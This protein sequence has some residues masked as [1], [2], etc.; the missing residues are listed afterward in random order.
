M[1]TFNKLCEQ[2]KQSVKDT[3]KK[4]GGVKV[5]YRSEGNGVAVYIDGDR[6]DVYPNQQKAERMASEFIKMYKGTN[7]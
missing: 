1:K 4:I 5:T 3:T 2:I 7:K 6:L